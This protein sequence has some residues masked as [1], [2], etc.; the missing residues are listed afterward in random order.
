MWSCTTVPCRLLSSCVSCHSQWQKQTTIIHAWWP[1]LVW[2][3]TD[4]GE[5]SFAVAAPVAWNRLPEKIWNLQS[6]QLFKSSLKTHLFSC[7][8]WHRL[9][10]RHLAPLLWRI[11][12]WQ[13]IY[14]FIIIILWTK[15][16]LLIGFQKP[17]ITSTNHIPN[18]NLTIY[19]LWYIWFC[20]PVQ[21]VFPAVVTTV[22]HY[23]NLIII[24]IIIT[25]CYTSSIPTISKTCQKHVAK[26]F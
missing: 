13:I 15:P 12:N 23:R 11:V 4:F 7:T 3:E 21:S 2:T 14:L 22:W 9:D 8:A 25:L 26:N 24:I 17:T 16:D 19:C 18:P 5:H 10:C 1:H 20:M 6:L